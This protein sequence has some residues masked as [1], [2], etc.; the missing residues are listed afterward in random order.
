ML[1]QGAQT[2]V[3]SPLDEPIADTPQRRIRWSHRVHV[4]IHR[5]P[6]GQKKIH[7]LRRESHSAHQE[8]DYVLQATCWRLRNSRPTD[9]MTPIYSLAKGKLYPVSHGCGQFSARASVEED[10]TPSGKC[11]FCRVSFMFWMRAG[12]AT[13]CYQSH[14]PGPSCDAREGRR[15]KSAMM[16]KHRAIQSGIPPKRLQNGFL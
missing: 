15:G 8:K 6:P 7:S 14:F 3:R 11:V 13:L 5:P 9:A 10:R 4:I 16:S 2:Q 1:V 12:D